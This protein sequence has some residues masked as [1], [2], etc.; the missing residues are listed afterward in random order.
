MELR[1]AEYRL[2]TSAT[3]EKSS[4]DLSFAARFSLRLEFRRSYRAARLSLL[5]IYQYI[6]HKKI[7]KSLVRH[8]H[9]FVRFA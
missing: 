4:Q 3:R 6:P 9:F 7:K 8:T 1:K 5:V 2:S